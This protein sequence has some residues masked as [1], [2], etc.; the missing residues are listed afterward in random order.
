MHL[1]VDIIIIIIISGSIN[2]HNDI[3]AVDFFI[4]ESYDI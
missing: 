1:Y 4:V 3:L 2:I